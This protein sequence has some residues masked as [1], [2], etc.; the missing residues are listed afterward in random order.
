VKFIH[1]SDTHLGAIDFDRVHPATG[2]NLREQDLYDAFHHVI[3]FAVRARPDFVLHAGDLFD[4][5]RPGNRAICAA[6]EGFHRLSRASIPAVVIAGNHDTPRLAATGSPLRALTVLPGVH[7]VY[8]GEYRRIDIGPATI[9]AVADA[10]TA[11]ALQASLG[12]VEPVLL[13]RNILLLHAGTT[14]YAE[15][16]HSGEF[17]EHHL[18]HE[19]LRRFADFDYIALGHY[20]ASMAVEQ[21]RNAWYCGS[22]ERMS[23]G[24]TKNTPGFLEVSLDPLAARHHPTPAR[25]M[26]DLGTID[27]RGRTAEELL[28]AVDSTVRG[29]TEGAIA[30]LRLSNVSASVYAALRSADLRAPASDALH[31]ECSVEIAEEGGAAAAPGGGTLAEEFDRYVDGLPQERDRARIRQLGQEYLKEVAEAP[32]ET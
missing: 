19:L 11:E 21:A 17:N 13:R 28:A 2:L 24:E 1:F 29:K 20:H 18:P 7:A 30:R 32:G 27:G 16:V 31:F 10:A 9:H 15:R 22:T 3:D 5:A 8:D 12:R 4:S 26:I 6:L 14:Y 25:R 23:F